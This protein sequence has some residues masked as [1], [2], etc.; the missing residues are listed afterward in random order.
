MLTIMG[1]AVD[2]RAPAGWAGFVIALIVAGVI[3]TL[4]PVSGQGINPARSL[5]PILVNSIVG[6][7]AG[8]KDLWLYI[9]APII[10]AILAA[11][12]YNAFIEDK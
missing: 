4:G 3:I 6:D 8:L 9:L 1:I 2:K 5:G 7:S 11:F 12:T 10:G